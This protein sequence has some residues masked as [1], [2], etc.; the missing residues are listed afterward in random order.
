MCLV[1]TF[2]L[3]TNITKQDI[4]HQYNDTRVGGIRACNEI[5]PKAKQPKIKKDYFT[6]NSN[7]KVQVIE[8]RLEFH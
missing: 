6:N 4:T 3:Y 5:L 2:Y 8:V 1:Y 7:A